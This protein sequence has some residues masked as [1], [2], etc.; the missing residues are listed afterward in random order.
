MKK[1]TATSKA[2]AKN[3]R[4]PPATKSQLTALSAVLQILPP[5]PQESDAA[6]KKSLEH[7]G[8]L[9]P[10]LR[11]RGRIVDGHRRM[12]LLKQ[13][14][15]TPWFADIDLAPVPRDNEQAASPEA[16]GRAFF[17]SNACRRELNDAVR[18]AIADTL[19]TLKK[20][21]NQHS[22]GAGVL[23]RE[24]AARLVRTSADSLDRWRFIKG[25]KVARTKALCGDWS[26]SHA[27]RVVEGTNAAKHAASKVDQNADATQ[28][29]EQILTHA[30][31]FG[32]V[33]ADCPWDYG[34]GTDAPTAAADPRR[35][36]PTMS[37]DD[38]KA[39]PVAK[40][41]AKNA[42]LFLW[43]PNSLVDDA[44]DVMKAWGFEH[45]TTIVWIKKRA[46][47]TKGLVQ[48]YHETLLVGMRGA[49]LPH[50]KRQ[51]PS[52]HIAAAPNGVHSR[53]PLWFIQQIERLFPQKTVA[54]I[55]LFCRYPRPGWV[56]LGNQVG[57][58]TASGDKAANDDA[59]KTVKVEKSTKSKFR[60]KA[61]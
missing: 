55:E 35:H 40:V 60:H 27:A 50:D 46:A 25:N 33:L 7:H 39:M 58:V 51:M 42:V 59:P 30:V 14:K 20:G 24:A 8:Q 32:V 19:A 2:L 29:L 36:Y 23:S 16:L 38:I 4:V 52:Y 49:G 31:R 22:S 44:Q 13:L 61:A 10:I 18:A 12:R 48:P 15:M 41:A 28:M 34:Q 1:Y 3:L 17:E 43:T 53:K 26:L 6:L 54:K 45:S 47:P 11:L 57:K 21:D 5:D 37:L 9:A 56:A